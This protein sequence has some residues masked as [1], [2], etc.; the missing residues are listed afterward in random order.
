M[1]MRTRIEDK[2]KNEPGANNVSDFGPL[3]QDTIEEKRKTLLSHSTHIFV[4]LNK[5]LCH[6]LRL[7]IRTVL[8]FF[9]AIKVAAYR[10]MG[11]GV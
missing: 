2:D 11:I 6:W 1:I 10:T 9:W 5:F 8:L 4:K 3:W 7:Y